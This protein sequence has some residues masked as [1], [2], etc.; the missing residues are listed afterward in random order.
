VLAPIWIQ[1]LG[2]WAE[3]LLCLILHFL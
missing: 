3:G 2:Y 1:L